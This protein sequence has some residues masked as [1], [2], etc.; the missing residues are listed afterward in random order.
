ML[1]LIG[2]L[3]LSGVF[4]HVVW[5]IAPA[6]ES[7]AVIAAVIAVIGLVS[8]GLGIFDRVPFRLRGE[9]YAE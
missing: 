7:G 3:I 5:L 9:A 2:G 4:L 1:R 6:F 8:L